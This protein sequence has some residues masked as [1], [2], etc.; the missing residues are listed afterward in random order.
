MHDGEHG[1]D[2]THVHEHTHGGVTHTHEHSHE[3]GEGHDHSHGGSGS[4]KEAAALLDFMYHHNQHHAEELEELMGK[5][6]E[7]GKEEAAERIGAA[8]ALFEQGN[9]ELSEAMMLVSE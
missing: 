4:V 2:H 9:S 1:H 8:V 3:H 7:M 5:L 6:R